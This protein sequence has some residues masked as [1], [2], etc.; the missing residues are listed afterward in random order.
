[1]RVKRGPCKWRRYPERDHASRICASIT[2]PL[3]AATARLAVPS[4]KTDGSARSWLPQARHL[5][6]KCGEAH[7]ESRDS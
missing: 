2:Y 3:A 6:Y 7:A 4:T 5:Y 1:M